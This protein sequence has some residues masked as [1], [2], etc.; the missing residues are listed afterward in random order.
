[1]VNPTQQPN[2]FSPQIGVEYPG[3]SSGSGDIKVLEVGFR[4]YVG[5][6][7][8]SPLEGFH[9]KTVLMRP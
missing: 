5:T 2:K 7:Q 1:M 9:F 8:L 4:M 3:I 6:L